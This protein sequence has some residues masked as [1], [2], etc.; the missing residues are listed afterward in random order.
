MK[1]TPIYNK[2]VR[3]AARCMAVGCLLLLASFGNAWAQSDNPYVIK[4]RIGTQDHYLAHVLNGSTW[5]LTNVT[6]F[7]P[8]C[9]WYSGIE[10]NVTGTNHNYYFIDDANNY[11]FLSAPMAANGTLS[12]S[13]DLPPTYLLSNTD[14]IYYFYDWDKDNDPIDG[15]GVARGHQYYGY[16]SQQCTDCGANF[17]GGE[18]WKVFWIAYKDGTWKLTSKSYYDVNYIDPNLDGKGGRYRQV[19]VDHVIE[20]ISN[21]FTA[22]AS[23]EMNFNSSQSLSSAATITFPYTYKAYTHY[24]FHDTEANNTTVHHYYDVNGVYYTN[25]SNIP[26]SSTNSVSE[27]EWTL[28]GPGAEFLSFA[29][30]GNVWTSTSNAPTLY[31]RTENKTGDKDATLKLKVTYGNGATQERTS[32]VTAKTACQNPPQAAAPVV[33]YDDVVVTWYDIADNYRLEW[34]K[35]TDAT[36]SDPVEVPSGSSSTVSYRILGLEYQ[37]DY[38]YRVTAYCGTGWSSAP[39]AP[40]GTFTTGKEPELLIY[41][42]V[43]GGGRVADVTGKTE[44]VIVNCDSIGAI[45]GGNDIAGRVQGGTSGADGSNITLGVNVNDPNHYDDYGTTSA[46]IRIGAVY[47]GG[48]GF[49]AYGGNTFHAATATDYNNV[50]ANASVYAF[51][52]TTN[53]WDDLV[54]TNTGTATVPLP[55]IVKTSITVNNDYVKVDSIFGGAKNAFLTA[56]TGKGSDID[57]KGGTIFAV[58]GGNNYGGTQGA[59]KQYVRVEGTTVAEGTDVATLISNYNSQVIGRDFGIGYL[60]GGGNKVD[61]S[62]TEVIIEGGMCDT[63]FAGGNSA[64]V[65]TAANIQVDCALGAASSGIQFGKVFSSAISSCAGTY[66]NFTLTIDE[67]NYNWNGTGIYN[68]RTLFGGNNRAAMEVVPTVTLTTGSIGTVYGG[69]NA[70]DMNAEDA[71]HNATIA[72]DF[73]AVVVDYLTNP[74]T[75]SPINV[76]THVVMD[77]PNVLVDYLYGGC[78]MSDVYRSTWVEMSDGHVGTVYGGCNISGDVGSRYLLSN[79]YTYSPRHEKYQAVKG[80]TYVKVSGGHIYKDLFAGS[81]GRYHCNDGRNYVAG[82]DFDNLDAEGRYIGLTVPSHNETHVYV[83]GGE[84]GGSVY[85]GGNLACVGFIN[86]ST[87]LRFFNGPYSSTPVFVGMATV[88]M[89]GGHVYGNVFGGGNMASIWGSNSVA[90]EG[91]TIDGALY[92]GNDRIGLVA[93]ITNRVLPP[94]YG[95][96][97]DGYTSLNDVRTYV[98]LTG[99]PRVNTVY[100]GG[101][102]DYDDYDPDHY[103]NPNDKPVQSNTF[104]DINIKGYA[105]TEH[106]IPAGHIHTVYGGGNGVTVTGSTTVFM[107]VENPDDK[108]HVDVIFGGNNKGPLAILPDIILLNGLV[109]T[110]YG[111]CNQGAMIGS[112]NITIGSTTY[113]NLGSRVQLRNSYPSITGT[114][115]AKVTGAVYG[116]CRMNGVNNNS[117]VIVE[118]GNHSNANMFGGSDISGEVGGTSRV[119]VTGG[120]IAKAFGGGNGYYTYNNDGTVYTIPTSGEPQLVATGVTE[121]PY[122]HDSRIDMGGGTANNLYAG[123]NACNS[124]ATLTNMTGGAVNTG[125]YGGCNSSGNIAGNVLVNINNGNVG[126]DADNKA[127]IHGGGYGANTTVSG[128][129]ELNIGV[130]D[131]A[132][133]AVTPLIYGDIYGGSALGD[134]NDNSND[135]TT[136]NFLNGTLHGNL[137]GG[138]LGQKQVGEDPTTA[139]AAK[140]YGK[141]IVNISNEDQAAANCFIDLRDASVFGCNNANGSPQDD[142]TVNVYKTAYNFG[143]YPSGDNYTAQYVAPSGETPL[144]AIDQVFG[145]G[146]EANYDPL[147]ATNKTTVNVF[148]CNN[149]IRRVFGGGNAAAALGVATNIYGGRFD[150]VFGGGNGENSAANIGAGGVSLYVSGGIINQLFGGN[151]HSGDISGTLSV[152]VT[153]TNN[154][155]TEDITE[156]FAGSNL[157]PMGSDT[158]PVNLITTIECSNPPVN[159]DN[160]YGGSNLATITGNITLN[161]KGG[162]YQNVFCGSKG[163]AATGSSTGTAANIVGNTVLNLYGGTIVNAFGGSNKN[164]NITGSITVNVLDFEACPLD[165]TN[166]YGASNETEYQPTFTPSSGTER[167][168]PVVNVMHIKNEHEDVVYGIR[169]NVFGGGNAAEVTD[170]SPQVNIGYVDAMNGYLPDGY[171]APASGYCAYVSGNVYGG[172]NEAG[173]TGNPVVNMNNGTV[174]SGI[175]GGCNTNGTVTGN[176]NVNI[177]DGT[178][179]TS[180]SSRMTD[181]IFGGGE[182]QLTKTTGNITVTVDYNGTDPI[183]ADVYGGS[184]LG[185][186][187]A[188]GKKALI[189]YQNGTLYGTIYGGGMGNGTYAAEVT[190]NTEIAISGGTVIDGLYGGCNFNGIVKGNTT[191][192]ITN[193]TVGESSNAERGIIYGGGL[194]QS[195]KV[196]GSVAVTV[197][198]GSTAKVWGDMYGGSAK[199]K[200]NCN[201]GGSGATEGSTT[202]IT[203]TNG[204]INGNIYGGGHGPDG[205]EDADVYGPVTVTVTNG[206]VNNV[207]GGNNNHGTP[208]NSIL[209]K[210]DGGAVTNVFGGGNL[211]AYIPSESNID[212]SPE[213]RISGGTISNKVVG[214]CKAADI[215]ANGHNA[216]PF[217]NISGGE[218]CQAIAIEDIGIYGGCYTSGTVYGDIKVTITGDATHETTIGSDDAIQLAVSQQKNPISVHGGGFGV[219][220]H[221][222]GNITVNYGQILYNASNEEIH[223]DYPKLYGDLYGGSALGDVNSPTASPLNTTTVNILNGSFGYY[224]QSVESPQYGGNIYGGGLG[225]KQIGDDPTTAIPAKTYG[226]VHV[227]IG[228]PR[229]NATSAP[230]GMASLVHCNVF[231]CNNTYGSPQQNVYVD[232]YQTT[233]TTYDLYTYEQSSP[234][235]HPEE[236]AIASV[237]GGGNRA[238]Y[239]PD[240]NPENVKRVHN[241]VHYCENTIEY[242]YGGGN[243]AN[244]IGTTVHVDGGRHKFIFGGGNGQVTAANVGAGGVYITILGGRVGWYFGGCNMH[245]EVYGGDS[246]IHATYGCDTGDCPCEQQLVVDNYYFGANMATIYEGITGRIVECGQNFEFKNVYAGS[247]LAT[248]YGDI[249]LTVNGGKIGNLFG[250]CEGS[251]FIE[252]NVKKYPADWQTNSSAYDPELI[253]FLQ[254]KLDNEHVDLGG[255]GGNIILN[256]YGGKIGNVYGGCDYRGNIEGDIT[257]RIDSASFTNEACRLD[258]NYVYGGSRWALYTPL[259]ANANSPQVFVQNGHVNGAVYGGSMGG[260]PSHEFGNGRL[261]SNPWVFIG[262]KENASHKVRIGGFLHDNGIPTTVRGEGNV[263]GGGN[264]ANMEGNPTVTI[265]GTITAGKPSTIIEGDVY[266]GANEGNVQGNTNVIIVPTN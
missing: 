174:V 133:A 179:G 34:K 67:D 124:G 27:Y 230:T 57:V 173:V 120:T 55:T 16:T 242:V 169:E 148:N 50:P 112:H 203:L 116:G 56:T 106:N 132:S 165:L 182:G 117:L 35:T 51:S 224:Q 223:S 217:I 21:G 118:G 192:G 84:V 237:F 100:G 65:A 90:V 155:C 41:G 82:L 219:D 166:V 254:N 218:I 3:Q 135:N 40:T 114:P 62:T 37:K 234:S 239:A 157:A 212:D 30:D 85:A 245:G 185:Q 190:G 121:R 5:E 80:A 102:G 113:N 149:T 240:N 147:N 115:P 10:Q 160:V 129:V 175:Y 18:C 96:A 264:A 54:W 95:K 243:A 163:E 93:Q 78:Q 49:Y 1:I 231:G 87:P 88:R 68:V 131:A 184:A 45:Y 71:S 33:N 167:I 198:N 52:E 136:I 227:N 123:G 191:V 221:T 8:N 11:R 145:G 130:A 20:N 77:N 235:A 253:A 199:G 86:E 170:A 233:H 154:G 72:G 69:G 141:V 249:E 108:D 178:L 143:D 138:G 31:Y 213:V 122:T 258:I 252:A 226:E 150:Q 222:T 172:G 207:F 74:Y 193:G 232:V 89:N 162:N 197:N 262:D 211:A 103:C 259:N 12:L 151:N 73:G 79:A 171:T 241:T 248:V 195:T 126:I 60:F 229:P 25:V 250:G 247:R 266:G 128:N 263:F 48:N 257:I 215:G 43:Y 144:Y 44:V 61:G 23:Y 14:S 2:G 107:N 59:A 188:A 177:Y 142:V 111:G 156:F 46:P 66:P 159:I 17:Q 180:T 220:T 81:N 168:S 236:Y 75:T 261:V 202:S 189:N 19:T 98:S 42:S 53:Q 76:S 6:S 32:T 91:G 210:V 105:D 176:I 244:V 101:N 127:N 208:K 206:T 83:S 109:N 92:G 196:K 7:S 228:A 164:G 38:Q 140:V 161:I 119:V 36:W 26:N 200:V 70:G 134:V 64:S 251:Y 158:H 186:V 187:G 125:I 181:G 209:V 15:G 28:S 58:F 256:L 47:G 110:V 4:T 137:Y 24:S 255:T 94:D 152:N 201:D 9:L 146:N 246:N 205:N 204:T 183:Y 216:N 22:L 13:D 265:Q 63:V 225:Q 97:S 194:G 153:N 238:H 139:I 39:D 29:S 99:R 104:V 214:G 260:D